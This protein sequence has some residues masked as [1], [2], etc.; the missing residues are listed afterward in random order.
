MRKKERAG[1]QNALWDCPVSLAGSGASGVAERG[2]LGS[3]LDQ[4]EKLP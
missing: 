3:S 1:S 4:G 2:C